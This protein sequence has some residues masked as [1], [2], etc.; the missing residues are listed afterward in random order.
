MNLPTLGPTARKHNPRGCLRALGLVALL[1]SFAAAHGAV[2]LPVILSNHMLLQ[3]DQPVHIWGWA[4]PGEEV[5]V[6]LNA[7]RAATVADQNGAWAVDLPP[8]QAGGPFQMTVHGTNTIQVDDILVGDLWVASGQSNMEFPLNG[9]A[10][11]P[12]KDGPH[13]IAAANHPELRLFHVEGSSINYPLVDLHQKTGWTVCTPETVPNFSA[14]AYFF[15]R[16]LAAT[17]KISLGLIDS[18]WGGTPA[19][20]WISLPAM[21]GNAA[22]AP[23]FDE[24]AMISARRATELKRWEREDADDA[25]TRSKGQTPPKRSRNRSFDGNTPAAL[26]NGMI[27]PLQAM[28]IRGVI[29]YQGE[30][31]AT[32]SRTPIYGRL[33]PALI[34]DWRKGWKQPEMP[35]LFVQLANY[36]A[37]GS[38]YWPAIRDAQRRTLTLVPHTGMAVAIDVGESNNVHPADKQT[39]A[40]RLALAA[41]ATVYGEP[42]EYSGPLVSHTSL[43]AGALR[44][45]F[46]HAAGLRSS[47]AQVPGFEV[48]GDDHNFLPATDAHI[49][50]DQIVVSNP[51]I[52]R[53]VY[54]RYGFQDDPNPKLDLYNSA[55][56]PAATFSIE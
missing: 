19:E 21:T 29:W 5:S 18:T 25:V 42:I 13:E 34:E 50:G 27:A 9:F 39:V 35:F 14:I 17:Q 31:S 32:T 40:H 11:A 26:F 20:S 10:G 23:A 28:H 6:E 2:T 49:E 36:N 4:E 55:G 53:P 44:V 1:C 41:R 15:G 43:E 24:F 30:G 12:L 46:H 37:H 22:L 7:H 45:W 16:E 33:F 54:V 51:K 47:G 56:L 52:A 48:A 38:K 3:R 8:M